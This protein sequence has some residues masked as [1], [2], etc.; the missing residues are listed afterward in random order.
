MVRRWA[1]FVLLLLTAFL[2]VQPLVA[3]VQQEANLPAC[4][5]R[6]G[7]H[8][9]IMP[10]STPAAMLL[11]ASVRRSFTPPPCPWK[12]AVTPAMVAAAGS[13]FWLNSQPVPVA[14]VF[15]GSSPFFLSLRDRS[16]SARAPP[17]VLL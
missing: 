14:D 9:C 7:A 15:A 11:A 6:N 16:Q 4:C 3:S 2:P 5:R 1:A 12:L 10:G 8:H 17:A 13:S